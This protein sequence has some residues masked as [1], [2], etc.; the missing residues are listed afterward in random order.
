MKTIQQ[1]KDKITEHED[2]LNEILAK[3]RDEWTDLDIEVIENLLKGRK[4][5]LWVMSDDAH[6]TIDDYEKKVKWECTCY[7]ATKIF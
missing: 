7:E 6:I 1:I 2:R 4:A 3:N 5:L